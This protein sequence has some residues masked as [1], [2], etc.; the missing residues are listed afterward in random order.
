M[1]SITKAKLVAM[2]ADAGITINGDQPCDLQVHDERLYGRI[3]RNRTIAAGETYVEGWWDC[4]RLDELFHRALDKELDQRLYSPWFLWRILSNS[5]FNQQTRSKSKAV[6]NTHYNLGNDLYRAMLGES[7][8]YTCAYWLQA[9]SLDAAQFAKYDLVCRKLDLQPGDKV[10]E[11]G[12]GFGGLAKYMADRYG[13]EVVAISI[14]EQPVAYAR[15]L[16]SELP[17][18]VHL[19]D[20]RDVSVYNPSGLKFDK[21]V[22]VGVCEH[23]GY[24]NYRTL[25]KIVRAQ[26]KE[27]G[28]FMLHTIGGNQSKNFTEPWIDKYIFPHGMLPSIKQLGASMENLFVVEDLHNFGADYDKTL[29]AWHKNFV[30]DWAQ[31]R[32]KYGDRFYRMWSYYLLSCAGGFRARAMQLWEFVLSP[33]GVPHG[34]KTVR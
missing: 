23:V 30:D 16:C 6:A 21:V 2:L 24:K 31:H 33:R 7:M 12:S 19:C 26:I 34:Y 28:L 17:V 4:E 20:Y 13:C 32:D 11:V 29:M 27:D 9:D 22:S 18:Q 5:I 3:A 8:A 15:T 1:Q 14:A 25:M 10:L